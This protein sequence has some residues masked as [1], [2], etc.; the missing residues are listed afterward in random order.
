MLRIINCFHSTLNYL[1]TLSKYILR[2]IKLSIK[3]L[4]NKIE[5]EEDKSD[6]A[7]WRE[8]FFARESDK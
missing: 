5:F 2:R 8:I 4:Q 7:F 3:S 1:K 6:L